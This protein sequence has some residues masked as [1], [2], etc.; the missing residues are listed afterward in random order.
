MIKYESVEG[1]W[2][3]CWKE[4]REYAIAAAGLFLWYFYDFALRRCALAV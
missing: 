1:L 3:V 4:I 2:N